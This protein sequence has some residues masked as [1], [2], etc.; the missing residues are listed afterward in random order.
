MSW[1]NKSP[2]VATDMNKHSINIYQISVWKLLLSSNNSHLPPKKVW[3][4]K[5]TRPPIHYP[6]APGAFAI[7]FSLAT[8]V[9]DFSNLRAKLGKFTS[10]QRSVFAVSSTICTFFWDLVTLYRLQK[11]C[12]QHKIWCKWQFKL[13]LYSSF[14]TQTS[15]L[16]GS[17]FRPE[18]PPLQCHNKFVV[19]RQ[20]L[21]KD[22]HSK[23]TYTYIHVW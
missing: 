5:I 18:L 8:G 9:D 23:E 2:Q 3:S 22:L 16:I 7:L 20:G 13:Y 15:C 10:P 19:I 1:T 12:N 4:P 6:Q 11:S 17:H 14:D 21:A